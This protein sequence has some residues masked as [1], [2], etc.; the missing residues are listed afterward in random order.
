M[1]LSLFQWDL[2]AVGKGY[3]SLAGLD[4]NEARERFAGVLKA[5]PDH[6]EAG[7]GMRD[8]QC[9]EGVFGELQGLEPEAAAPLLWDRISKFPLGNTESYQTLRL[10]LIRHLLTLLDGSPV[11]YVPPDLCRGF[12]HLLLGEYALA[13]HHLR[14]VLER[15]PENGRLHGYLADALWMQGRAEI[16]G[17]AYAR[18]LLLAPHGVAAES[19]RNQ[20]LAAVIREYGPALAPVHGFLQGILPLVKLET[21]PA[22]REAKVYELLRQAEQARR[23]GH[24]QAMVT[25]RRDLKNLAPDVLRDYLEWLV[26]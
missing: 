16:A 23:L 26:S 25:A 12:L 7:R 8:L 18:A 4:F 10:N 3:R 19:M 6:P 22:T 14:V 20:P 13:E 1:Q 21:P 11:L 9:W 15:L 2:I 5:L 24:H 17:A